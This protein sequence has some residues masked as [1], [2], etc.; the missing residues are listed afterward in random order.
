MSKLSDF[1]LPYQSAVEDQRVKQ[2][3]AAAADAA[4]KAA[5]E[6]TEIKEADFRTALQSRAEPKRMA[7]FQRT[8]G[9]LFVIVPDGSPDGFHPEDVDTADTTIELSPPEPVE[10][11]APVEPPVVVDPVA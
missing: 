7:V 4:F 6:E 2:A 1:F 3:A 8:D 10:P 11:P 5:I 9:S